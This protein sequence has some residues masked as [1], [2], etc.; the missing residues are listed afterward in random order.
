MSLGFNPHLA[1]IIDEG[2]AKS[3]VQDGLGPFAT[4]DEH[5]SQL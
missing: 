1:S 5:L 2:E 3:G 4:D